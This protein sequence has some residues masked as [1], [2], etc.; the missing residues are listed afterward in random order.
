VADRSLSHSRESLARCTAGAALIITLIFFMKI[1]QMA[2][3]LA[4]RLVPDLPARDEAFRRLD[5]HWRAG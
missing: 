1:T 4:Y 3:A 2:A 5:R